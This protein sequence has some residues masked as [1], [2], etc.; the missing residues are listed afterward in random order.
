MM[1]TDD[2]ASIAHMHTN[3]GVEAT[4]MSVST[5]LDCQWAYPQAVVRSMPEGVVLPTELHFAYIMYDT[6]S[7]AL[8]K[9]CNSGQ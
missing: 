3:I 6:S 7:L 9:V 5:N 2:D 1:H 8:H 4:H